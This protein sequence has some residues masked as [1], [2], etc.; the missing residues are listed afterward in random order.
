MCMRVTPLAST[1]L[2]TGGQTTA[3]QSIYPTLWAVPSPQ[4]SEPPS[5]TSVLHYITQQKEQRVTAITYV[6]Q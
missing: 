3:P 6:L 5:M 4:F 1:G 2:R